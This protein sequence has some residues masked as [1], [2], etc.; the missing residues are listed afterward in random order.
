MARWFRTKREHAARAERVMLGDNGEG[1]GVDGAT[2]R[3]Q[4]GLA[5]LG[6]V[7]FVILLEVLFH[8]AILGGG[9]ELQPGQI[10][11]EEI[12]APF[13][14]DVLKSE[15]ELAAERE[16][17]A[18]GVIPVFRFDE[19]AQTESRKRFGDFVTKVY[20][21]RDG[22][23]SHRQK[24]DLLGQLG[25]AL[26]DSTREI[27]LDAAASAAVEERAR[28]I[29]FSAYER[30]I[31]RPRGAQELSPDATVMLVRGGEET[32]VRIGQFV[33]RAGLPE[34]IRSE[35]RRG[36]D[37]PAKAKAVVEITLPFV[38]LNVTYD[39]AETERRRTEAR[40]AVSPFT[41]RDFKK[42][43]IIVERGQRITHDHITI[44]RSMALK[45]NE[46]LNLE[47][48]PRRL[49]PPVGRALE[50][51]LLLGAFL[52]YVSLRR[53]P[54]LFDRRC[55]LLI[56]TLI[57]IVMVAAAGVRATGDAAQFLVPIA[58]LAMLV[59]MLHDF[60]FAIVSSFFTVIL[61]ALYTGFWTP[62]VFVSVVAAAV[63]A[64]SVETVR[65]REDFYWSAIKVVAAYAAAILVADA[66]RAELSVTTLTRCGWGGLNGIVS[67]GVVVVTLPLFERGFRV[68]TDIT[69]L[70]LADMN[71]PLLRKMA[72][73]APG[74]Y[75]H[76]IV[77][78]NLAEAA[79]E[80]IGANG[81][82][83]RV[84]SYYHDIGKLVTPGYFVENQQGLE[85]SD[86]KHARI[87]PKVSS[88]VIRSHVRDGVELARK[89]GLP[90]PLIDIIREHHGTSV[91][92]YFYNKAV[93]EAE[94]PSEVSEDDYSY[95]GPR[96]RT[97]ESAIISLADTI[98]ARIR[99]IGESLTPK[100]VEA[101][102]AEIVEKRWRDHQLDD[103][104]LTLA[105]LRKIREAFS[106]VLIGMYHQRIK[107]PDQAEA[108]EDGDWSDEEEPPERSPETGDGD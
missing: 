97:R 28:E 68:T 75:H 89:E 38:S 53:R 39:S 35:A 59:A 20:G 56:L 96:P 86:S 13:D 23:E 108:V 25:V 60:E 106:R 80:A 63:A 4:V 79:A 62:F 19:N 40:E 64:H 85:P 58:I 71:K 90:E 24:L 8:G 29:L 98:E 100:R 52:L 6:I 77:V 103:S 5:S 105:D 32:M 37:D 55:Q 87:R 10:A 76:S 91:M 99:S 14:F 51:A 88:L 67:M 41:G 107:Y 33:P 47:P 81:L 95:P 43:E 57:A 101:E 1:R 27:L 3:R 102:V 7:A 74:S 26:S 12:T 84:G 83:A 44:L 92:E 21:I 78:G 49:L 22:E 61:A 11:R 93:E 82:L 30:G 46:L 94:D 70:E 17:A 15:E 73:T 9:V 34:V 18:A 42:D 66:A 2:L 50:A 16:G 36:F 45:R 54:L 48:G 69:L 31:L 104:E 72:M 65:H